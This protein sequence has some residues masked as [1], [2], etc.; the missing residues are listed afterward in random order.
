MS[1]EMVPATSH[2]LVPM[3]PRKHMGAVRNVRTAVIISALQ[4]DGAGYLSEK[5]SHHS[6]ALGMLHEGMIKAAPLAD[7][8]LEKIRD[9]YGDV[10]ASLIRGM[11]HA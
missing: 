1:N 6:A 9:A 10:A 2:V 4:M 11:K 8:N 5:G 3:V 7:T